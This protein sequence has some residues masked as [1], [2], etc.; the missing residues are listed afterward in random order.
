MRL[1]LWSCEEQGGIGGERYF[2]DHQ[3][4]IKDMDAVFESDSGVF[5]P[6]GLQLTSNAATAQIVK[7]IG[8]LL[9]SSNT[10]MVVGGGGGEDIQEWS[11]AGVPAA[12]LYCDNSRYFHFHHTQA[13]TVN[14]LDRGELD[15]AAAMWAVYAYTIADID[16]FL[17]RGSRDEAEAVDVE[18]TVQ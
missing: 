9:V 12:S 10:S 15:R 8:Q 18:V 17:P 16:Q 3:D 7:A 14:V 11:N 2:H 1:A 13:D 4:L 6:Y 5:Q